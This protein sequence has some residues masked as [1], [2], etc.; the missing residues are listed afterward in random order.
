MVAWPSRGGYW[1]EGRS[2]LGCGKR[3]KWGTW[4]KLRR[5]EMCSRAEIKNTGAE[6]STCRKTIVGCIWNLCP[7][8][9]Q[10]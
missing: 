8:R 3:K 2:V 7:R 6:E 1:W 5:C 10:I 4:L 9:I